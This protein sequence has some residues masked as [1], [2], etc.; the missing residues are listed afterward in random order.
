[1][2]PG[3]CVFQNGLLNFPQPFQISRSMMTN[4]LFRTDKESLQAVCDSWFNHLS[5]EEYSCHPAA[6]F[7]MVS[8]CDN[9]GTNPESEPYAS[10]G[11][12]PYREVV[13][14]IFVVRVKKHG[15][16][17]LAERFSAFVPYI[18]VTN[19]I[20]MSAGREVYG[21]PKTMA[22]IELPDT[23]G[24]ANS[25]YTLSSVSTPAFRPGAP[26]G[27]NRLLSISSTAGTP[28]PEWKKLGELASDLWGLIFGKGH[29]ELPGL[30]LAVELAT[31]L[32]EKEIPFSSSRQL[33]SIA[34][35]TKAVYQDIIDFSAKASAF[36]GAGR[37]TGTHTLSL[38]EQALFPIGK[39]LGLKDGM[40]AELA[41]WLN[42]D[43]EFT[44]GKQAWQK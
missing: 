13:I 3:T 5:N 32:A 34:D 21:M 15:P 19:G 10:W 31:L 26:F 6:P 9:G 1:M 38:P 24:M 37:L 14:T 30:G 20:V 11:S 27:E 16:V 12:I 33:R 2:T 40:Q 22:D 28:A 17:W 39:D 25:S 8:F 18:F 42:W 36:H 41:F 43:F 44:G 29:I 7:V 4:F 23:P 35:P